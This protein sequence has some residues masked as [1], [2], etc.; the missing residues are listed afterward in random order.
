MSRFFNQSRKARPSSTYVT[1]PAGMDVQKAVT[2]LKARID[3]QSG[4]TAVADEPLFKSFMDSIASD[5]AE[6]RLANCRSLRV[7][8]DNERS[9]LTAQYNPTMQAA[10][11]AYRTLRTRLVKQQTSKGTRSLVV[12]SA[13]QGEGK[14]LTSLNLALC[15]AKIEN[16]PVLLVDADLRSKGLSLAMGNPPAPGLSELLEGNGAAG[17]AIY[18]TDI[19]NLWF[20]PAGSASA[21]PPEL[22]S[23]SHWKDWMGWCSESFRMV[24][25]DS[26]PTL[27]L[28]DFELIA[29]CC[30]SVLLVVRARTS[31]RDAIQKVL[32]QLEPAKLAG[33]VFNS[34]EQRDGSYYQYGSAAKERA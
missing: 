32:S 21:P 15:Y 22:F 31:Q 8:R 14:T 17:D 11:E 16:W 27:N 29:G 13:L 23:S 34:T 26:P 19:S 4:G 18:K 20:L 7:P 1:D 30:E 24:I 2:L 6:V 3:S 12:T 25:V 28:A 10:V 33:V 5:V 9:F